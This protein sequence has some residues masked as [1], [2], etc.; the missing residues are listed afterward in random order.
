[1]DT[2][3]ALASA[4]GKAGVS[5]IRISGTDA[6]AAAVALCGSLPEPRRAGLR[7]LQFQGDL[8]DEAVVLVFEAGASFT[9]EDVVELHV[10]GGVATVAA[11]L[12]VLGSLPGLRMAEPGEFSRRA[13]EAGRIDLT[14]IE[15]LADLIDAETEAQRK[16]AL[17]VLSGDIGRRIEGWR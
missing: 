17:R 11:V 12:R 4:R 9:G 2:I 5:V 10:H 6:F 16:Q 14:Q 1:M 7:K 13:L 3:F 8:L 15:G